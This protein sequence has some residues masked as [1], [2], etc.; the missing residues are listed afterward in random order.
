MPS[1]SLRTLAS[2]PR[3][4]TVGD[5]RVEVVGS[6]PTVFIEGRLEVELSDDPGLQCLQTRILLDVEEHDAPLDLEKAKAAES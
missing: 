6:G 3:R 5:R 4:E 1:S 2:W